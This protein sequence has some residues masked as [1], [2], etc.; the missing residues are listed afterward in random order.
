MVTPNCQRASV[1][2]VHAGPPTTSYYSDVN[3]LLRRCSRRSG[4]GRCELTRLGSAERARAAACGAGSRAPPPPGAAT[5]RGTSPACRTRSACRPRWATRPPSSTTISSDRVQ[6]A[7]PVGD[8]HDRPAGPAAASTEAQ[9]RV[10]GH[11]VEALGRLVEH[12]HRR[13]RRAPPGPGPA[14]GAARR[15]AARPS[16]PTT[17][18]QPSGCAA[19]QSRSPAAS[20]PRTA[21]PRRRRA[22]RAAGSPAPWRGTRAARRA[23]R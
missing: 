21:P 5:G 18:S 13:A 23:G 7:Q 10:G 3:S 20:P 6:P 2:R 19:T 22:G 11:R 15:R 17:V 12:Q 8:H 9:H 14:A 4:G 16:S 1:Q